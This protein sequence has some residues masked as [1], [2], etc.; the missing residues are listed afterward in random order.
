MAEDTLSSTATL[1]FVT[2]LENCLTAALD[3]TPSM[4][5]LEIP[6]VYEQ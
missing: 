1:N 3:T 5:M 4:A 6:F 2:T